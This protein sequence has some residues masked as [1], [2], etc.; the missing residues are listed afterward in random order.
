MGIQILKLEA[1]FLNRTLKKNLFFLLDRDA[2]D[3]DILGLLQRFL[4]PRHQIISD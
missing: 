2:A 4:H 1:G 3:P